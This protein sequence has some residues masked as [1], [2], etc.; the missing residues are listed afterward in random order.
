MRIIHKNDG[1]SKPRL[2]LPCT[3]SSGA[4]RPFEV[5]E[6]L[7]TF[8]FQWVANYHGFRQVHEIRGRLIRNQCESECNWTTR[9]TFWDM[10]AL[11]T[12]SYVGLCHNSVNFQRRTWHPHT[13]A[14]TNTAYADTMDQFIDQIKISVGAMEGCEVGVKVLAL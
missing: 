2:W 4:L 1:I 3:V 14:S 11:P 12:T 9:W 10:S 8:L 7:S 5:V 6:I 13:T